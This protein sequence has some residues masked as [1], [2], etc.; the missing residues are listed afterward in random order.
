MAVGTGSNAGSGMLTEEEKAIVAKAKRPVDVMNRI[1]LFFMFI[2]VVLLVFIYF[3]KKL[4]EGTGWFDSLVS[5]M[6]QFLLWDIL[7]M[8]LATL[9]KFGLVVRYNRIV[10]KI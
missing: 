1:R 3:G 5:G 7:L 10:K 8:L 4:W 9:I 2:A 6:Y